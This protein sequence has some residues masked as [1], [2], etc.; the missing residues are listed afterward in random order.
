MTIRKKTLIT[1]GITFLT[2]FIILY[3]TS[4]FILL[5]G[6]GKL[7]KE[8]VSDKVKQTLNIL[9]DDISKLD[10][11]TSD[12]AWWD[13]TYNFIKDGNQNYINVNLVDETFSNLKLNLMVFI[14]VSGQI[15]FSKG[16]DL[17]KK[18]AI[19][20]LPKLNKCPL[21]SITPFCTTPTQKVA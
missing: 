11:Y 5:K 21:S 17:H 3:I 10:D 12:W 16:F 18:Q 19:P 14:N 13:D 15:I 1:I 4:Q 7:E 20:V 2:L 6:F 9:A 8:E